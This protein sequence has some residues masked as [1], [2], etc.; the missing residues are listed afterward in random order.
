MIPDIAEFID[1]HTHILPGIDDGPKSLQESAAMAR[2]YTENGIKKII[3]TPH[4]IPGTAWAVSCRRITEKVKE[5]KDYFLEENINLQI[6]KGMEIAHHQQII[7]RL[8]NNKLQSLAGSRYFLLEPSFQDSSED[9]LASAREFIKQGKKIILAHPERIKDFQENYV[10]LLASIK[11]GVEVQLNSGSL[12]GKF[13]ESSKK[14]AM[15][16]IAE[17]AVHY[18]ASDAH[19]AVSRKPLDNNEWN[20]LVQILGSKLLTTLCLT[21]PKKIIKD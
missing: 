18:L 10:P 11:D 19:S 14:T 17:N 12:L 8:E 16:L 2:C 6:Y 5:V 20:L 1:I 9:V 13:G 21:N 7:H 4:F 3:A 15:H